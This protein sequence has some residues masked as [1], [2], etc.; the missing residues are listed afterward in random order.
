MNPNA[1]IAPS[2]L[3][4]FMMI[5]FLVCGWVQRTVDTSAEILVSM[6]IG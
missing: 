5:S 1:R 3:M 2:A 4:R 6:V